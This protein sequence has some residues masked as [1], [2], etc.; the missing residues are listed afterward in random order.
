[1]SFL[2][3]Q[4]TGKKKLF[5]L[6]TNIIWKEALPCPHTYTSLTLVRHILLL[7]LQ[8]LVCHIHTALDVTVHT[9]NGP[10]HVGT[11]FFQM[12]LHGEQEWGD[13]RHFN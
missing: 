10:N 11:V 2:E 13:R 6:Q 4:Y 3:E 12:V 9:G 5:L 8:F 1:M 7:V